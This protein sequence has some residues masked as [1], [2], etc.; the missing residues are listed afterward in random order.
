MSALDDEESDYINAVAKTEFDATYS[1]ARAD[2]DPNY[3]AQRILD[4]GWS[5]YATFQSLQRANQQTINALYIAIGSFIDQCLIEIILD[6]E[7][8]KSVN[9]P[10]EFNDMLSAQKKLTELNIHYENGDYPQIIEI[11]K[12]ANYLKHGKGRASKK[13]PDVLAKHTSEV[14][15]TPLFDFPLSPEHLRQSIHQLRS[16]LELMAKDNTQYSAKGM[17]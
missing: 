7:K 14:S 9:K 5:F 4:A 3:E 11:R 16:F 8:G 13:I 6:A 12:I 17:S 1:D 10:F 2:K 15:A